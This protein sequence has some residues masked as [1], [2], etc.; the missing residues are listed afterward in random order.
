MSIFCYSNEN[1]SYVAERYEITR[2]ITKDYAGGVYE[3]KTPS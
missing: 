2:V 1:S 3:E